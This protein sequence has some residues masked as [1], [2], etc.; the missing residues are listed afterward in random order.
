MTEAR[1]LVRTARPPRTAFQFLQHPTTPGVDMD[2]TRI[3][4]AAALTGLGLAAGA[5]QQ[6]RPPLELAGAVTQ[7]DEAEAASGDARATEPKI[8][9]VDLLT[10]IGEIFA[11]Q[12]RVLA[13]R[14]PEKDVPSF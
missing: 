14:P 2:F 6:G 3:L 1:A 11:E 10:Y 13:A 8:A 5:C 9:G 7:V 4:H 12:Q